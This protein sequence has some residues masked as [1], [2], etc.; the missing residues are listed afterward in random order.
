MPADGHRVVGEI[1][2]DYR[3]L[4]LGQDRLLRFPLQ[5]ELERCLDQLLGR[6]GT[7]QVFELVG[8]NGHMVLRATATVLHHHQV[9]VPGLLLN[10][11]DW[12]SATLAGE[13]IGASI[14]L[15]PITLRLPSDRC[16]SAIVNEIMATRSRERTLGALAILTVLFASVIGLWAVQR[17]LI[18]FPDQRAPSLAVMGPEWEEVAYETTDD[19]TLRAWYRAPDNDGPVVVVFSGNA[20]N[21]A[22][23]ASLGSGLAAAGLG[24]LLTDY[25]G[26]GGNPGH[27]TEDGLARDA[28]AAVAFV[29]EWAP[30]SPLVYLGESLGAAVSVELASSDPPAVLVLRSP[31]TSLADVGR[32]HYPWLPVGALLKDQYPSSE[33]IGS[34]RVPTLVVAGDADSIVPISQSREIFAAA[35][36]PKQLVVISGADHNDGILLSGS[37]VLNEISDFVARAIA[38]WRRE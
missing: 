15:L 21:R 24:V 17:R 5:Q 23:R 19:L 12:H 33:R 37:E 27:P 22:D 8:A 20:G 30:R 31:F 32:V 34:V 6:G 7:A 10:R 26:Y 4:E 16:S 25:R 3:Q 36:G 9:S 35:P 13:D 28:R 2:S 29:R 11:D 14:T 18:Y 1:A 38:T